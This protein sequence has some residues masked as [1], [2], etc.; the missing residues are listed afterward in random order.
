MKCASES[1]E[2]LSAYALSAKQAACAD[3]TQR[4]GCKEE[5]E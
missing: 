1:R 4:L 5:E 2:A 3:G